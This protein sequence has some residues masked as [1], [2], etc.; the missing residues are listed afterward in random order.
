M[1][2]NRLFTIF[3][4]LFQLLFMYATPIPS[5]SVADT[6]LLLFLPL[7]ILNILNK[8]KI[9]VGIYKP[10]FLILIYIVLQM[11]FV[12]LLKESNAVIDIVARTIRFIIYLII[13]IIFVPMYFDIKLG[14]KIL[15]YVCVI[16]TL[17][18]FVQIILLKITGVYLAGTIPGL[19]IMRDELNIFNNNVT[20]WGGLIRPRS[21]FTEPAHYA[22]YNLLYLS[23]GLFSKKN[24]IKQY[25]PEVIVTFGLILSNSATG[26]IICL[27]IWGIWIIKQIIKSDSRKNKLIT[28]SIIILIIPILLGIIVS[29][30][31]FKILVERVFNTNTG[32]LGGAAIGRLGNYSTVFS[33][34]ENS[35]YQII[36]GRGMVELPFFMTSVARVFYYY[37]LIGI[38]LFTYS[39]IYIFKK[40]NKNMRIILLLIILLGIGS[41][42]IFG[43]NLL[44]YFMFL[45][46][47]NDDDKAVGGNIN[48]R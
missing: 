28:I 47:T 22:G 37:G 31:N 6:I 35:I 32:G 42:S 1:S 7:L 34:K 23:L 27:I 29:S 18:L 19:P 48:E 44:Y 20:Q 30:N 16:S 33:L 46:W 2:L 3:L 43:Y 39:L 25:I 36:F 9:K 13:L 10:L 24:N 45:C 26:I 14:I 12:C 11:L 4:V 40:I 38:I 15:R 5:F 41:D 21:I 8:N 17:F